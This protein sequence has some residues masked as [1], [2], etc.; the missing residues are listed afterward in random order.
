MKCLLSG[1]YMWKCARVRHARF[2]TMKSMIDA[3]LEVE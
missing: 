1:V 2:Q 3:E